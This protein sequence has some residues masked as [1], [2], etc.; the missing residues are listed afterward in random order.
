MG[1]IGFSFKSSAGL[2]RLAIDR[3][4]TGISDSRL[5]LSTRLCSEVS[6]RPP[7][8]R[9]GSLKSR[10]HKSRVEID[11]QG[12]EIG[13]RARLRIWWRNP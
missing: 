6:Y 3:T 5:A 2:A 12:G 9:S 1:R 11:R 10:P 7:F 8:L 13:R 4:A